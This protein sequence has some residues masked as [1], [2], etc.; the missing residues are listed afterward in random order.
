MI[1]V[2]SNVLMSRRLTLVVLSKGCKF[3]SVF[4]FSSGP[5]LYWQWLFVVF[6]LQVFEPTKALVSSMIY[7]YLVTSLF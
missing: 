7:V 2:G 6:P 4:L 5:L 1:Y 3:S